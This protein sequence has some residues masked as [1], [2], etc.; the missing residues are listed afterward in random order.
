[1]IY[2]CG[3]VTIIWQFPN[4]E[5]VN[6]IVILF[7]GRRR[8]MMMITYQKNQKEHQCWH[9]INHSGLSK[10]S[11]WRF[12]KI[13][14]VMFLC[15]RQDDTGRAC[16]PTKLLKLK[17]GCDSYHYFQFVKHGFCLN[18][19]VPCRCFSDIFLNGVTFKLVNTNFF[20]LWMSFHDYFPDTYKCLSVYLFIF[21]FIVCLK[22]EILEPKAI[23]RR[24]TNRLFPS[25][26]CGA[27]I[28]N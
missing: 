23:T 18:L 14:I 13:R 27:W 9:C 2:N 16:V 21:H 28:Q 22:P 20:G 5:P 26:G 10:I 25:W 7:K 15:G 4:V 8:K 6:D 17:P 3:I 11:W 1:M 12:C 19:N 24:H